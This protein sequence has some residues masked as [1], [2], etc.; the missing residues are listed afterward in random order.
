[1]SLPNYYEVLAVFPNADS[2]VISAAYQRIV[3]RLHSEIEAGDQT[4]LA[5]LAIL[6][7]AFAVLGSVNHRA[8]YDALHRR[9]IPVQ[10]KLSDSVPQRSAS[11]LSPA[12]VVL[13]AA[14]C[15]SSVALLVVANRPA[16]RSSTANQ[17]NTISELSPID[18]YTGFVAQSLKIPDVTL[19]KQS[20]HTGYIHGTVHNQTGEP[21]HK[22]LL[23]LKT[24]K[25]ER[26]FEV[27]VTI[28][29]YSTKNFQVFVGEPHLDLCSFRQ[30]P[31]MS[32]S[33]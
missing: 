27:S 18:Q 12:I 26:T 29:S 4:A 3:A 24:A 20:D 17:S 28:P 32:S 22:V 7:E 6:D 2:D 31:L 33:Q 11:K 21:I 5:R 16:T 14:F 25:W 10:P 23:S 13:A 8:A 30:L 9:L 15:I 1:M 19:A